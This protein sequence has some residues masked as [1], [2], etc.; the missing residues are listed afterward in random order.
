MK[1]KTKKEEKVVRT[2][3]MAPIT[4]EGAVRLA[5]SI[6]S[7]AYTDYKH[8]L[9]TIMKIRK[10]KRISKNNQKLLYK[11]LREKREIETFYLEGGF[12]LCSLGMSVSGIDVIKRAQKEVGYIE[13][14][15]RSLNICNREIRN[16]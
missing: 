6:L 15:G 10:L 1:K 5:T 8:A 2:E 14:T 7:Y 12:E 9:I 4:E 16:Y 3:P 11:S 13:V